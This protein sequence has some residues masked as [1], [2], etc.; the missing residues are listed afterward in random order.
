ME[1][2][3]QSISITQVP[4]SLRILD[5]VPERSRWFV[6]NSSGDFTL[7]G[8]GSGEAL[9]HDAGQAALPGDVSGEDTTL[10]EAGHKVEVAD[11]GGGCHVATD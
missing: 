2:F 3:S 4:V 7:G 6:L 1:D 8:R 10:K 5:P 11:R 9:S